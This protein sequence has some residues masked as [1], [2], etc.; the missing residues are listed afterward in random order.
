MATKMKSKFFHTPSTLQ[1]TDPHP[2][3]YIYE[4]KIINNAFECRFIN[5]STSR[6]INEIGKP[7]QKIGRYFNILY[8]VFKELICFKPQFCY[9][10]ITAKG[11]AFTKML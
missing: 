6:L 7:I 9:L 4:S 2:G 5:L 3:Q 10:A 8:Q 11:Y 1:Y